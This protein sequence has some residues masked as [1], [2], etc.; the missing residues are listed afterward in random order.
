M[1]DANIPGEL[2]E[3]LAISVA[4]GVLTSTASAAVSEFCYLQNNIDV[5][6]DNCWAGF[7]LA[8]FS[9]R[10]EKNCWLVIPKTLAGHGTGL[11]LHPACLY[12]HFLV[13]LLI[14]SQACSWRFV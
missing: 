10:V 12:I 13:L 14:Q 7:W 9:R 11:G 6:A 3:Q 4:R 8:A 2:L 1:P 5:A